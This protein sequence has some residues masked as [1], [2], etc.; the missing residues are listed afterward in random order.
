MAGWRQS[1]FTR[2][3]NLLV[4]AGV[5]PITFPIT[6]GR[7]GSNTAGKGHGKRRSAGGAVLQGALGSI[8]TTQSGPATINY[9][10]AE[11]YDVGNWHTAGSSNF[12][13]P[14]GVSY[15][16]VSY[17]LA[18]NDRADTKINGSTT[19]GLPAG[20]NADEGSALGAPIP[21]TAADVLTLATTD[22]TG[23]SANDANWF[24]VEAFDPDYVGALLQ[25]NSGSSISSTGTAVAWTSAVYDL[26]SYFSGAAPTRITIPT[27][28]YYRFTGQLGSIGVSGDM[29]CGFRLNGTAYPFGFGD[30]WTDDG[31][32]VVRTLT[33]PVLLTAGDY[34]EL[35]AHPQDAGTTTTTANVNYLSVE[36]ANDTYQR[37][38][39]YLTAT[40]TIA[41]SATWTTIAWDA[42]SYDTASIW[43]A[44]SPAVLT[45]PAGV[46]QMRAGFGLRKLTGVGYTRGRILLDGATFAGMAVAGVD[47]ASSQGGLCASTAWVEV[48]AGQQVTCQAMSETGPADF[49]ADNRT[50]F[51]IECR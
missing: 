27:T 47:G 19:Y 4:T 37:A 17:S 35:Y 20:Q 42:E 34:V 43:N 6:K 41:A 15:A 22:V 1:K 38:L 26:A 18:A 14:S 10:G 48:T 32:P 8:S 40:E 30:N 9:D 3:H 39:V 33:A 49:P 36:K 13:V 5:P 25:Q 29:R 23:R 44:G 28:G 21:V 46:T 2:H 45:I 16:R 7:G 31:S 50:F 24:S 51:F 12:V 11:A